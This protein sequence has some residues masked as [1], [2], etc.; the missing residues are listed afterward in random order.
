MSTETQ[1]TNALGA[2]TPEDALD[3][4]KETENLVIV[5]VATTN[6]YNADHFEGAIN[7]PIVQRL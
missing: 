3:Y 4:M 5:D 6:R 7:I 1:S 2:L